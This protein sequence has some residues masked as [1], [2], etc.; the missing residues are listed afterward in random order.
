MRSTRPR[1]AVSVD[2]S[3]LAGDPVVNRQDAVLGTIEDLLIDVQ[4]G[5]V[6]YAVLAPE[7]LL[8]LGEKPFAIPWSALALDAD[9]Q[10]FIL[11]ADRQRLE[12]APGFDR[13]PWS[14]THDLSWARDVHHYFGVRPYWQEA[15]GT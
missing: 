2:A 4:R 12:K 10:C 13:D 5:T 7:G 14:A 1:A 8:G 15:P 9:R 3:A 6:A 11:D